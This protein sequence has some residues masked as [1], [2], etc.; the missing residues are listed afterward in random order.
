MKQDR[1]AQHMM[2][3]FPGILN[4]QSQHVCFVEIDCSAAVLGIAQSNFAH[5]IKNVFNIFC[6]QVFYLLVWEI[7]CPIIS[8]DYWLVSTGDFIS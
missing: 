2:H 4:F 3:M 8:P 7:Y 5:P 1:L 6:L